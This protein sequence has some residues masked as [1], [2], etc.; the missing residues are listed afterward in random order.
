M[1][2]KKNK[3][4]VSAAPAV[5]L[6]LSVVLLLSS[7]VGS[8]RATL[9]YNL[10]NN[11]IN[12]DVSVSSIGVTLNENGEEVSSRRYG[13]NGW[14]ESGERKL[15]TKM[16][17]EGEKLV[18][19]KAYP[20]AL[21]VTNSGAIDSYVRVTLRKKW[22]APGSENGT[23]DTELSPEFIDLKLLTDN[24]WIV[25]TSASANDNGNEF[26]ER[27]VLYY[28]KVLHAANADEGRS[29][30]TTPALSDTLK[31]DPSVGKDIMQSVVS[32][33]N[34]KKV[35]KTEYR[36]NGYK[37]QLDA[38]VDAVQEHNAEAAIM[39]AWGVDVKI[40]PVSGDLS[41]AQ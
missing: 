33:E 37:F 7:V 39:S 16:L 9:T 12:M 40:D 35:I 2:K 4:F 30:E 5:L 8:A 24:G 11:K 29:A 34:G 17:G 36:Y 22:I 20:E 21:S 27:I 1:M 14:V 18:L 3:R 25:D 31:I 13:D 6:A 32:E 23:A 28:T 38:E 41:L 26:R 19:G 10:D 15:L